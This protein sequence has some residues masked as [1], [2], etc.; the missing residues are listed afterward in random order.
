M[1][2]F[3]KSRKIEPSSLIFQTVRFW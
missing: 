1:T 2:K 3:G